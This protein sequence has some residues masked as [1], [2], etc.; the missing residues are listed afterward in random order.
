MLFT[1]I[2]MAPVDKVLTFFMNANSR[3]N[4]FAAD[5]YAFD[6]GF[7][8]ELRGGLVKINT[9]KVFSLV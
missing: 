3:R 4:E 2:F 1:S 6:L 8:S 9:G 5:Q 7:G